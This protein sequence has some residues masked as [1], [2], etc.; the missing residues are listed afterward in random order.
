[1]RVPA[2]AVAAPTVAPAVVSPAPRRTAPAAAPV[3]A[4][5]KSEAPAR[6]GCSNASSFSQQF[7]NK[8]SDV[9]CGPQAEP[10]VT[11]GR[12]WDRQSAVTPARSGPPRVAAASLAPDTR[13]VPRHVYDQRR[14]TNTLVVPT[15]YRPVW[16]DD[17]LNP[18]RA[19][20]SLRPARPG[21]VNGAPDG[22]LKVVRGDDRLNPNRGRLSAAGDAGTDRIWTRTVPRDLV[23]L[24]TDRPVVTVPTEV[25]RSPAETR[26]GVIRLSTRSAPGAEARGVTPS[27]PSRYVRVA[28]YDSDAEARQ[29]AEALA[30]GGLPMRLGTAHRG[31]ATYKVVLAGPFAEEGAALAALSRVRAA[32][33]PAARLNR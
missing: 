24:P 6:S 20:R 11:Y 33:Y 16:S 17:R 22:Y 31:Q 4:P 21:P 18:H 8:G 5:R 2:Q 28:A 1:R 14:N 29:A 27:A 13:V 7:I 26:R 10:P 23:G 19:E 32:G 12:G 25:A 9:R 3:I 30:R 15:G